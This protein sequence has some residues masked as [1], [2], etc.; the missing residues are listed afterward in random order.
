MGQIP[1]KEIKYIMIF[2]MKYQNATEPQKKEAASHNLHKRTSFYH[3][4][5]FIKIE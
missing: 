1:C 4:L 2:D 5:S 3:K